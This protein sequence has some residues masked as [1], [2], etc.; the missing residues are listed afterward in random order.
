[1][2]RTVSA[3]R[4]NQHARA[5]ALPQKVL[6]ACGIAKNG[7]ILQILG[8]D[9]AE[10]LSHVL[11][12][13]LL[14]RLLAILAARVAAARGCFR[15]RAR[16]DNL[17]RFLRTLRVRRR[18]QPLLALTPARGARGRARVRCEP[19]TWHSIFPPNVNLNTTG[20][21]DPSKRASRGS[22]HGQPGRQVWG[23]DLNRA[24]IMARFFSLV[25]GIM[26][27]SFQFVSIEQ[28][29]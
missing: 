21:P 4:R 22:E 9:H 23:P 17:L 15:R 10:N 29:V 13:S 6:P 18:R 16:S 20:T 14:F 2:E 26:R 5:R 24:M 8:A 27:C 3:G 11:P 7:V 28:R 25:T 1:M 19:L 12:R